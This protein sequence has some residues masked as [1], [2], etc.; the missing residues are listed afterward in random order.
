MWC[1]LMRRQL[2][3]QSSLL[4]RAALFGSLLLASGCSDV[5]ASLFARTVSFAAGAQSVDEAAGGAEVVVLLSDPAAA[6]M[7][8]P[9]VVSGTATPGS[10]FDAVGTAVFF[11]AGEVRAVLRLA[12]VDDTVSESDETVVLTLGDDT[13]ADVHPGSLA[14]HTL[15]IRND[16]AVPTLAAFGVTVSETDGSAVLPVR[17]SAAA[18]QP[19]TVGYTAV[20]GT[21]VAGADFAQTSGTL[22]F[23]SGL[24]ETSVTLQI[25]N[26]N[27]VEGTESFVVRL[28]GAVGASVGVPEAT[29]NILDDDTV[30]ALTAAAVVAGENQGRATFTLSLSAATGASVT[31]SWS[32]ADQ[33]AIAGLDYTAGAGSVT[34]DPGVTEQTFVVELADDSLVEGSESF[35]VAL[36][37]P[38]HATLATAQV[39]ATILDDDL[40]PV[41]SVADAQVSELG[42]SVAVIVSLSAATGL[43]VTVA[44]AT[45]DGSAQ[46]GAD[47]V[48][49][50][51]T[52]TFEPGATSKVTTLAIVDD[53]VLEG[54]ET[55]F[56]D[57]SAP[58]HAVLGTAHAAVTIFDDEVVP[59]VSI[60]DAQ[61]PENG[62]AMTFTLTVDQPSGA[63]VSV[64][65]TTADQTAFAGTDYQ[66]TATSV[67]FAP[68]TVVQTLSVPLFDD[69]V[70]TGSQS[71]TVSIA[72]PVHATLGR[73]TAVGTILDDE[74]VPVLS[75]ADATLPE[76]ALI[77]DLVVTLDAPSGSP[78]SVQYA[79][80]DFTAQ[81]GDDYLST[82]GTL[83]FAPGVT[84][85]A[86]PVP[87]LDDAVLEGTE[88]FFVDVSAP[89]HA[90]LGRAHA[91]AT[92]LDDE[93]V[94]DLSIAAAQVPEVALLMAFTVTLSA[95]TG[96]PVTATYGT[97]SGTAAAD[98]DYT[99]T[100]GP[101]T[102]AAGE[103]TKT[104]TVPILDDSDPEGSETFSVTLADVSGAN[105]TGAAATGTILDDDFLPA[106]SIGDATGIEN[107]GFMDFTVALAAASGAVVT[108]D[109]ATGGGSAIAGADYQA[110]NGVVTF[111]PGVTTQ[112]AQVT[113]YDNGVAT[114]SRTFFVTLTN[115]V[116]AALGRTPALGTIL[117]DDVIPAVSIADA[118]ASELAA[119]LDVAVTLSAPTGSSVSV[120]YTTVDGSALQ[121]DDY[122]QT[123]GTLTFAP[124]ITSAV[125]SVP[126]VDDILTQGTL[127]FDVQLSS[128]SQATLGR[129]PAVGTIFDDE[130]I[131]DLGIA[132]AQGIESAGGMDYVVTLSAATGAPVSLTFAT[133]G[134][135]A[136]ADV[137]YTTTSGPLTFAAGELTKTV[138][139]PILDDSDPE[140]S[141]T[142]SV[143]VA[144]VSGANVVRPTATGT[145][146]DDDFLPALSI[147]DASASEGSARITFTVSLS[148][149][150]GRVTSVDFS[151]IGGTAAPGTDYVDQS[152]TLSIAAG[153]ASTTVS[154]D[155]IAN[156]KD[157]PDRSFTVG[158]ANPTAATI[159]DGAGAGT[160]LDDDDPPSVEL[161]SVAQSNAES[162]TTV[163]LTLQLSAASGLLVSA[164]FTVN[165]A[166]TA[167][168]PDD[169]SI[170][171]SPALIAAGDTTQ[172]ITITV[173]DDA[174]AEPAET[175]V[176][177]LGA[178]SNATLGANQ[179]HTV[180]I[181]DNDVLPTLEFAAAAQSNLENVTSVTI[182]VRLSAI[183]GLPVTVPFGVNP[184]STA[185]DPADYGIAAS[186]VVIGA[187]SLTQTIA[188]TVVGDGSDEASEAIVVDLGAPTNAT[189]GALQTHTVTILDDDP[190]DGP[191]I[192]AAE[193]LDTD[194]NGRL[195]HVRLVF[196]ETVDDSTFDA[197][198]AAGT[199]NDQLHDV[200]TVW[201]VAGYSGVRLD[202][203]DV[204]GGYD[205]ADTGIDDDELWL[206]FDELSVGFD[207]GR[208]PEL[209]A[210]QSAL[211]DVDTGTC[212]VQTSVANC[213][214]AAAANIVA[215]DVVEAD[216][217]APIIAKASG[218]TGSTTLNLFFSEPV[219]AS[220]VLGCLGVLAG[221]DFFYDD[222]SGSDA[223]AILSIG[224]DA[225]ACDDRR[226]S[227]T[228]DVALAVADMDTDQVRA[229]AGL[230]IF[231]ASNNAMGLA[232]RLV[233]I[234][235]AP[236]VF[237]VGSAGS[238]KIQI[239]F[240]EPVDLTAAM[241]LGNYTLSESPVE[242]GCSGSGSDSVALSGAV[243]ALS[244][245]TFELSTDNPQCS[246]T[247]Y[248]LAASA[249]ITDQDEGLALVDPKFGTFIGDAQL[250]ITNVTC[251]DTTNVAVTFSK[252][253][254]AGSGVGGAENTARYQLSGPVAL[255]AISTAVLIAANQV[256][257]THTAPQT[258][259]TFTLVGSNGTNGDGFDD[260]GVGA[261]Q[262]SGT[263]ET[264]QAPPGDRLLW[265]GCGTTVDT[266]AQGPVITNPFA[267]GSSVGF[268]ASY[269]GQ[270]YIGPNNLGY[271]AARFNPDGSNPQTLSFSFVRDG[272]ATPCNG[273]GACTHQN[274]GAQPYRT[275]GHTG[276]TNNNTTLATGCGPDN[277]NGRGLF[278]TGV[279]RGMERLFIG[280][281]RSAAEFDYVYYTADTD[282]QLDFNYV[283]FDNMTGSNSNGLS[284]TAV[285]NDRLFIGMARQPN[286]RPDFSKVSFNVADTGAC[287]PATSCNATES[288]AAHSVRLDI[289]NMPYFGAMAP[290]ANRNWAYYVGVDSLTVF[291][292]LIYAAAGGHGR[293]DHNGGLIRSNSAD[294]AA[295]TGSGTCADWT[296][297]APRADAAWHNGSGRFSLELNKT[298][299]LIPGDKAF[300]QF[301]EYN[302][303]LF[304]TRTTCTVQGANGAD[305]AVH[306]VAGCN[307]GTVTNRQAQL[308]K[309]DPA[310]N[311]PATSCE[312]ADWGVVADGGTGLTNFAD[313]NNRTLSMAVANGSYLYVGFDNTSG[314]EIWRTNTANPGAATD[315]WT[316]V[317]AD[318]LGD[319][320]N[321]QQIYSAIS[322]QLGSR[323]YLYVSA[324]KG[325]VP[326]R[327]FRQVND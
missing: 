240:S 146:L 153:A 288:V 77:L 170:V 32:T 143:T 113:L 292:G 250:Y 30:P 132:D 303:R 295:C 301:A 296:E 173:V 21:A 191:K 80:S 184:A 119:T 17:L 158:L 217:A 248:Q 154:F 260:A 281:A 15:T 237:S 56:V 239:R 251:I 165:A 98:V 256:K 219:D 40:V 253:V 174:L 163:T 323:Y 7:S 74:V 67:L 145:I 117:D 46:A 234:A 245:T 96:M 199:P 214:V 167:L 189:L 92:V 133:T 267:D 11:H 125:V 190:C 129:T 276:C 1:A 18:G 310:L 203:R 44:V 194:G 85:L 312:A 209:T 171:A 59:A 287:D 319:A 302:G 308:W 127:S 284:S 269:A 207:T 255:G 185:A 90:I 313:A 48:A 318:G 116:N 290:V 83:S 42:G 307:D 10:D 160:V 263:A 169:Y 315:V 225:D 33:T 196:D 223:H 270:V 71:F 28:E 224:A 26:D 64:S 131:P 52:I 226:A 321:I 326:V 105:L 22:M 57:L 14:I 164:P 4:M 88:T 51:G 181:T 249:A 299:D 31:V 176:V 280:G 111:D 279:L 3:M 229:A 242:A 311:A 114:G 220:G 228:L 258:G 161:E 186:P 243:L 273:G 293:V 233:Q 222:Q 36:F 16:D 247:T 73:S 102:F 69:G 192:N 152:G 162:V 45:A 58:T 177:D 101:L 198:N 89:L 244:A 208:A 97:T 212:Y 134:G 121:P 75:I 112:T 65:A 122:L 314:V 120:A 246:S 115:P 297:I 188:V 38:R 213:L 178:P 137:D 13:G 110:T 68:G 63:L 211:R 266:F 39:P 221:G 72:N 25:A 107:A 231:D 81:G 277:E 180:T 252:N 35:A 138:T 202:T 215:A 6:E 322:I 282:A 124:G 200:T 204:I 216:R 294:P 150:S 206:A 272:T 41:V 60:V 91:V 140:G 94:P 195:D 175:V 309:C 136:A 147:G 325:G 265:S 12:L 82:A 300:A 50:A 108:V 320:A 306:T 241:A 148:D 235:D 274:T 23:A 238:Q 271:S 104:V 149:L 230:A 182:T 70:V 76:S 103:L 34:F 37:N 305:A 210:T 142:F 285:F 19:V 291:N 123:A 193:Y 155:L 324:G 86:I 66:A 106:L 275:L 201:G 268:L 29:I 144:N 93:V 135:S 139:V 205:P 304:V 254:Q 8:A 317:G 156:A 55:F 43:P 172:T 61:T 9:L 5:F 187:G 49:Y 87:L 179:T 236:S 78:V 289:H 109:W 128:P 257:L 27:E 130:V 79:T 62:G 99:T 84:A 141:E 283:D 2:A 259:G 126:L 20:S 264:L 298:Y 54:S 218:D 262:V 227:A 157:E 232:T 183:A 53:A 286:N 278:S 24:T 118:S 47:Y 197:F 100:S 151:T 316:Q 159:T 166:S 327:V 168:D 261:I 95:A